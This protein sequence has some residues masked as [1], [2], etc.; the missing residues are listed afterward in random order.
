MNALKEQEHVYNQMKRIAE[1]FKNSEASIRPH[2]ILILD[3]LV[4]QEVTTQFIG[5]KKVYNEN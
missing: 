5:E 3:I 2:F 1:I 4:H